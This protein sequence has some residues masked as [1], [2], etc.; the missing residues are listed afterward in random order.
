[1]EPQGKAAGHSDED[2]VMGRMPTIE[3]DAIAM[4]RMKRILDR[5]AEI[6]GDDMKPSDRSAP[7]KSRNSHLFNT[8]M[9]VGPKARR[10]LA[11]INDRKAAGLPFPS[12]DEITQHIGWLNDGAHR[13]AHDALRRLTASGLIEK[14]GKKVRR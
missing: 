4:S 3:D 6:V 12:L 11:F 10:V 2:M 5:F 14:A 13:Q 8:T 9:N 7:S 1:M